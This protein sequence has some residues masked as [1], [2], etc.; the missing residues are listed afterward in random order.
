MACT[1]DTVYRTTW[2]SVR[3]H[4]ADRDHALDVG[5]AQHRV[6][7]PG[8]AAVAGEHDACFGDGIRIAHR[9]LEQESVELGLG[10]GIG[11]GVHVDGVL[12]GDDDERPR[13]EMG[14]A[15]DRDAALLHHLEQCGLRLGRGAVDLVTDHDVG[16]DRPGTELEL[17]GRLVEDR[18]PGDVGRQQVGCELDPVPRARH[19][20]GDRPGQA[21]LAHAGHVLEQDVAFRD[22]GHEGVPDL[23][24]LA[25][26]PSGDVGEQATEHLTEPGDVGGRQL[27]RRGGGRRRARHR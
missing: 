11:A 2:G 20:L 10:Q 4:D 15:V 21:G 8:C 24:V 13:H 16:E 23:V 9:H 12:G 19:R 27:G 6:E 7:G 26:Q 3:T 1:S 25:V 5:Q 17:A 18:H 14:H 22:E